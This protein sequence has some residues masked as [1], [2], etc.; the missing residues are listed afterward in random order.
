LTGLK[1]KK[2]NNV[3]KFDVK[4]PTPMGVVY[5]IK[6]K[7]RGKMSVIGSDS[8]S[9]PKK[10]NLSNDHQKLGHILIADWRD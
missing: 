3:I 2:G 4:I 1:I 7:R 10:I 5:A 9:E 8:A 6:I